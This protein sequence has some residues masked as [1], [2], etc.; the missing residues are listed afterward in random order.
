MKGR[1]F[2]PYHYAF[3]QRLALAYRLRVRP[4]NTDL[5]LPVVAFGLNANFRTRNCSEGGTLNTAE[6][7]T[8]TSELRNYEYTCFSRAF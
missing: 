8:L 1:A 2:E 4:V 7:L 6:N 3:R 5:L